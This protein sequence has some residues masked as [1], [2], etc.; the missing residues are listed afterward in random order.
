M[1]G[2]P[3]HP[4]WSSRNT[5][6]GVSTTPQP[7]PTS[8]STTLAEMVK[9]GVDFAVHDAKTGEDITR[10]VLTQI[11]FEEENKGQNLLPIKFLR[12]LIRFYGDRCRPS[13]RAISKCR[14][15]AHPRA[16]QA[17]RAVPRRPGAPSPSRRMEEQVKRNMAMFADAMKMFNPFAAT[18][19]EEA[20]PAEPRG[21]RLLQRHQGDRGS[22]ARHAAQARGAGGEKLQTHHYRGQ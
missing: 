15:R 4:K 17:P 7:A 1:S 5:P 2:D 14:S 21:E 22:V 10:S 3:A 18:A 6:T 9:Q 11:I 13:C 12:Q 19:K 8:R 20:P 16:G